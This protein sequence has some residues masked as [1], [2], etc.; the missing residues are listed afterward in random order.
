MLKQLN[1]MGNI[2]LL[3]LYSF[4]FFSKVLC[5]TNLY[6]VT[7]APDPADPTKF[8]YLPP[9]DWQPQEWPGLT[10]RMNPRPDHGEGTYQGT[11][12]MAGRKVVI[13]GGDSGIGR[14]TAIAFAREGADIVI[15][16]LPQEEED[17]QEVLSLIKDAGQRGFGYPGDLRNESFCNELIS[18]AVSELGGLDGLVNC[19]G[20]QQFHDSVLNITTEQFEWTLHTNLFA[21]FWLTKAAIPHMPPGSSIV[22]TASTQSYDPSPGLLDYATTKGGIAAWTKGLA[23]QLVS[24]GIRVNAVA[25]GPFWTALEVTGGQN[26][27]GLKSFGTETPLGRPGQPAEIASAYVLLATTE[28]SY[29]TGQVIGIVGGTGIPG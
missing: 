27:A 26:E 15:N 14:A 9:F 5:D 25:P 20:R 8:Y 7:D 24:K 22:N 4:L 1:M 28:S 13:T 19:A 2:Y 18:T 3:T 6:N 21:L 12:K 29:Y 10:S 11:G 23:K 17:A 16:Y